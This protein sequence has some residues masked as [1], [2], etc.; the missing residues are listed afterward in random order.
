M[1]YLF[2]LLVS[3]LLICPVYAEDVLSDDL[4]MPDVASDIEYVAQSGNRID[5]SRAEEVP[6]YLEEE[7][8]GFQ[9]KDSSTKDKAAIKLLPLILRMT[10]ALALV[11][12]LMSVFVYVLKKF[13]NYGKVAGSSFIK[14]LDSAYLAPGK[15]IYLVDIAGEFMTIASDSNGIVFLSKM[16][17]ESIG[18]FLKSEQTASADQASL[19][20]QALGDRWQN[21][22]KGK[23]ES[24]SPNEKELASSIQN[25]I[26]DIH[27][28]ISKLKKMKNN[29]E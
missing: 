22:Q 29:I 4:F 15:V 14:I 19:F 28:Q 13:T 2:F 17:K 16:E 9:K 1:R 20:K 8:V 7:L 5:Q 3:F 27:S 11:V 24:D 21:F 26:S 10:A 23:E 12:A 25:N 6:S 18:N